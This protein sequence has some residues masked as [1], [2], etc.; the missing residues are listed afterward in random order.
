MFWEHT[1][2][3]SLTLLPSQLP[4]S[5]QRFATTHNRCLQRILWLLPKVLAFL[6]V[7]GEHHT[8]L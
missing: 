6:L 2:A 7:A 8:C 4:Q 1:P 3:S 5:M